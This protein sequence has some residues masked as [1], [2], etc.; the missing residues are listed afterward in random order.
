VSSADLLNDL[1]RD[2]GVPPG[3]VVTVPLSPFGMRVSLEIDSGVPYAVSLHVPTPP[4]PEIEFTL[5]GAD[6]QLGKRLGIAREPQ[7]GDGGFDQRVYLHGDLPDEHAARLLRSPEARAAIVALL[8]TPYKCERRLPAMEL[9]FTRQGIFAILGVFALANDETRRRT[10]GELA[11]LATHLDV[12]V[13]ATRSGR[14]LSMV[15]AIGAAVLLL[16]AGIPAWIV[17]VSHHNVFDRFTPA[18]AGVGIGLALGVA[19]VLFALVF[20]RGKARSF[21]ALVVTAILWALAAVFTGLPAADALNVLLDDSPPVVHSVPILEADENPS[22]DDRTVT[23]RS[24]RDPRRNVV[25]PLGQG[26]VVHASG[27]L[28]VRTRRGRFGWEWLEDAR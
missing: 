13:P 4:L 11:R 5:E 3:P 12:S 16:L 20:G 2:H 23:V 21:D 22:N 7:V 17:S 28:R 8:E 1:A 25:L 10:L 19:M 27:T 15:A 24:W 9:R 14:P 26:I 18:L 6:E